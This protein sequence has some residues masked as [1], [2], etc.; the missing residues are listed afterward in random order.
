[1]VLSLP[2]TIFI[3]V[4]SAALASANPVSKG[5]LRTRQ[6]SSFCSTDLSCSSS[7]TGINS[8]FDGVGSAA[9]Y[10]SCFCATYSGYMATCYANGCVTGPPGGDSGS[11]DVFD[12]VTIY[13]CAS[14]LYGDASVGEECVGNADVS[15][16]ACQAG[17]SIINNLPDPSSSSSSVSVNPV[18]SVASTSAATT[19]V[20]RSSTATSTSSGTMFFPNPT[21]AAPTPVHTNGAYSNQ[22]AGV[23]PVLALAGM[24]GFALYG[25]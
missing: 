22:H 18:T 11:Y 24:G 16:S 15:S 10:L 7:V 3:A 25:L 2:K 19:A 12:Q 6:T 9:A 13:G 14:Y 4:F 23:L 1:M 5:I 17:V 8:C 21:T 20:V